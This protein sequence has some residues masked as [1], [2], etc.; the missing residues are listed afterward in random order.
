MEVCVMEHP[1]AL[2][3]HCAWLVCVYS[4]SVHF[5]VPLWVIIIRALARLLPYDLNIRLLNI[6]PMFFVSPLIMHA[7]LYVVSRASFLVSCWDIN[8]AGIP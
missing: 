7:T 6:T 1:V 2:T 3:S 5:Q 4:I 8:E